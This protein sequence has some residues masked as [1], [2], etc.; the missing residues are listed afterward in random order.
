MI[1]NSIIKKRNREIMYKKNVFKANK[2]K[3]IF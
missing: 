1:K 3:K 2:I